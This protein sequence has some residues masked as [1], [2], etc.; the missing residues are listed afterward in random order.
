MDV[1]LPVTFLATRVKN[2]DEDDW[3][4]LKSEKVP[5]LPKCGL[6][7]MKLTS[8]VDNLETLYWLMDALDNTHWGCKGYTRGAMT[9]GNGP[10]IT[11][12]SKQKIIPRD[13]PRQKL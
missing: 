7:H 10:T 8:E 5:Q 6:M 2:P 4:K 11:K 9:Y 13:L 12:S 1:Q 3:R